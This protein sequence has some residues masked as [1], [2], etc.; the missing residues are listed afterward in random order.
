MNVTNDCNINAGNKLDTIVTTGRGGWVKSDNPDDRQD[1]FNRQPYRE[2][3]RSRE[4]GNAGTGLGWPDDF[5]DSKSQDGQRGT[6]SGEG[7]PQNGPS[8]AI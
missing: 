6:F 5:C 7:E 3:W 8:E 1:P 2:A 4:S